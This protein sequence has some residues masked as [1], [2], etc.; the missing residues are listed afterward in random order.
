MHQPSRR[1]SYNETPNSPRTAR[2][3]RQVRKRTPSSDFRQ[4]HVQGTLGLNLPDFLRILRDVIPKYSDDKELIEVSQYHFK[5]IAARNTELRFWHGDDLEEI[6]SVMNAFIGSAPSLPPSIVGLVHSTIGLIR[7]QQREYKCAIESLQKA[8]WI[9][10]SSRET[11]EEIGMALH[12]LGMAYSFAGD[13][14][15]ACSL[16]KKAM[17]NYDRANLAKNH[18]LMVTAKEK[19][20]K[21]KSATKLQLATV[22][23]NWRSMPT[24]PVWM[25]DEG[26]S[27]SIL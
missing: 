18:P 25:L 2:N 16:L 5:S 6:V 4:R 14:A 23:K 24:L 9:K 12:R 1:A 8:L 3:P 19:I 21:Y 7:Q 13:P 10:N 11:P 27:S 15:E 26:T 22:S 17:A 20:E